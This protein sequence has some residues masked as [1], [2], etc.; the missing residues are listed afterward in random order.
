M[1]TKINFL[2]S[3][4]FFRISEMIEQWIVFY[5]TVLIGYY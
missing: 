3:Y 2:T 1:Y 5:I 4:L